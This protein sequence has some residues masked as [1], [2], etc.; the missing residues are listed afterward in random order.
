VPPC[1]EI[2]DI[3][4]RCLLFISQCTLTVYCHSVVDLVHG[5]LRYVVM[6]CCR[7]GGCTTS[8]SM[9]QHLSI[10]SVQTLTSKLIH[11]MMTMQ[12]QSTLASPPSGGV[13]FCKLT[14]THV[15]YHHHRR[16][17]FMGLTSVGVTIRRN[18]HL[19]NVCL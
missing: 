18:V 19:V 6:C 10:M 16:Q 12:L 9:Q 7:C 14:Q 11:C 3:I 2:S 5:P 13:A 1:D 17:E 15:P 8:P 4:L